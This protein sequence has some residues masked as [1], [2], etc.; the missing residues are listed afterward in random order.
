MRFAACPNEEPTNIPTVK[1]DSSALNACDSEAG[2][3][4]RFLAEVL[5]VGSHLKNELFELCD[6]HATSENE[7]N[8][9]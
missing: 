8:L 7:R 2:G 6:K 4:N 9:I 3:L 1:G 5:K